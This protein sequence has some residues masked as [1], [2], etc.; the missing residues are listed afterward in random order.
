MKL[1]VQHPFLTLL[2]IAIGFVVLGCI[3]FWMGKDRKA[4]YLTWLWGGLIGLAGFLYGLN[5]MLR[6]R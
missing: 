2:L 4:A 3:E 5:I 1:S 6:S